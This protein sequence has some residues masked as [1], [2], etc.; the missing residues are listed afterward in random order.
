M[1]HRTPQE[2]WDYEK[3]KSPNRNLC[4]CYDIPK[5]DMMD[6]IENGANTLEKVT[7]KTYGCQGSQCCERQ[8]QRLIDI[9]QLAQSEPLNDSQ[10][11]KE[12]K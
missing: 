7:A 12:A 2:Q 1:A 3:L 11:N 6:A 8:V 5:I 9:Y 4:T 10:N